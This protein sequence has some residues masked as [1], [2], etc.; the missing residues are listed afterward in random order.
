[1]S[2]NPICPSPSETVSRK[3]VDVAAR[4]ASRERRGKSTVATAT[5]NIPCGSM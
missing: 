3:P 5:E 4:A 1:M 2:R